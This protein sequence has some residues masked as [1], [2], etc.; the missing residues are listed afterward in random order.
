MVGGFLALAF[1]LL[2]VAWVEQ[3][4]TRKTP[5]R[6]ARPLVYA[7]DE[8]HYLVMLH[9]LL[10]DG[11]LELKNN[12]AAAWR[13]GLDAGQLAAGTVLEHHV[14][15]YVDGQFV[16]WPGVFDLKQLP[17][18]AGGSWRHPP[19]ADALPAAIDAPEYS[20]HPPGLPLLLAT[21]LW[22]WRESPRLE[23]YAILTTGL[24]TVL[25]AWFFLRLLQHFGA[26]P[27]WALVA[28]SAA[29]L[30]TPAWHYSR[31]LFCEPYLLAAAIIGAYAVLAGV[32]GS[33]RGPLVGGIVFG[34]AIL[35]KPP[36]ALVAAPFGV[37]LLVQRRHGAAF[38]FALPIAAAVAGTL[39][40]HAVCFGSPW[41]PPQPWRSGNLATGLGGLLQELLRV[42]PVM[43]LPVI[44][45]PA[46][47]RAQRGPAVVLLVAVVA[48]VGLMAWWR[49]WGGGYCYGPRLIV[50]VL[51]LAFVAVAA[52]PRP[53]GIRTRW[54][55]LV[56]AGL[57]T[58]VSLGK[59]AAA[60]I[61]FKSAFG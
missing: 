15:Y 36:F 42:A 25:A 11:D 59:N 61:F 32:P 45:W 33:K 34:L 53:A 51:P 5:V 22:P 52:L 2:A 4:E 27:G 18:E 6:I 57:I 56:V 19:R 41:H 46:F 12:Y 14:G 21:V 29:F 37:W 60:A 44:A 50:P 43:V 38:A 9:S 49:D 8:P 35:M 16:G 55:G 30:A 28:T 31:S 10:R 58:A 24:V 17:R 54:A 20:T 39:V 3:R 48:Y 40:Y 23:T 47:V 1:L 26:R 13:G 7:G